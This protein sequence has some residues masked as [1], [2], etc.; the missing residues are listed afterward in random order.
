MANQCLISI[1]IC[2]A[3]FFYHTIA[4]SNDRGAAR[5][6]P[7]YARMH[8]TIAQTRMASHSEGGAE[9]TVGNGIAQQELFRAFA[10]LIVIIDAA[11]T[12][13]KAVEFSRCSTECGGYKKKL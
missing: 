9:Y 12:G 6:R 3:C 13:L 8:T 4:G 2:P 5:S 1:A 11:I 7:V 10:V